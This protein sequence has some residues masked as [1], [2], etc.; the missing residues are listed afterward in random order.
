MLKSSVIE[1][2]VQGTTILN[3]QKAF[4]PNFAKIVIQEVQRAVQNPNLY[5]YCKNG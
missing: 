5:I 4:V 1:S 2:Y 3:L